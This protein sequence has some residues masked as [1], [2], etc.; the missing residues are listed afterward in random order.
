MGRRQMCS[1][2]SVVFELSV[3]NQLW[4]FYQSKV[5]WSIP[6]ALAV[7]ASQSAKP[8]LSINSHDI[9]KSSACVSWDVW[10]FCMCI[11][12]ESETV[13]KSVLMTVFFQENPIRLSLSCIHLH[14]LHSQQITMCILNKFRITNVLFCWNIR[15]CQI[16]WASLCSLYLIKDL[17][18]LY[19]SIG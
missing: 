8:F 4:N 11:I 1:C 3:W 17:N 14:T 10:V 9:P 2:V 15:T 12:I 16:S 6:D 18:S 7:H 19:V 13:S 5:S